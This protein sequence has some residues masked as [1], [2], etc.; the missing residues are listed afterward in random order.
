MTWREIGSVGVSPTSGEVIVGPVSVPP[1]G[2]IEVRVR[3]TTPSPGFRFAFG[4]LSFVSPLGRELGVIKV[5][6]DPIATDYLLGAGLSAQSRTGNL[7]FD[8]RSFNLAWV[9]AGYPLG[10][11]VW[12]DEPGT[13]PADRVSPELADR[14]GRWL[15]LLRV[16]QSGR[17]AF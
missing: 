17:V 14:A 6:P 8:A 12:A 3:Q 16:G 1:Q 15:R 9:D 5:W 13:L 10:I 2:G 4:L 7:T 11:S